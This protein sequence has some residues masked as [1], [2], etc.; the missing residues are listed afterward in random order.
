MFGC[1]SSTGREFQTHRPTTERARWS[2]VLSRYRTMTSGWRLA[3]R[4]RC[5][6]GSSDTGVQWSAR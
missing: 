5:P 2:Y 6:T 4:R 1:R 3:D